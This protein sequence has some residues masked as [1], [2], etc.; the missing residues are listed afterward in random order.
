MTGS[1]VSPTDDDRD[2]REKRLRLIAAVVIAMASILGAIA[3]WHTAKV[4]GAAGGDDGS[5]VNQTL[6]ATRDRSRAEVIAR[7]EQAAF[8]R[9]QSER[10]AATALARLTDE[11][12][13]RGDSQQVE[14]LSNDGQ[15]LDQAAAA[16]AA[17]YPYV[18]ERAAASTPAKLDAAAFD[19]PARRD[20]LVLELQRRRGELDPRPD[21]ARADAARERRHAERLAA[22]VVLFAIAIFT[23]ALAGQLLDRVMPRLAIGGMA[24]VAVAAV[25]TLVLW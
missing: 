17:Q 7:T 18:Q 2:A 19:L 8:V 5:S 6:S 21:L 20:A 13:L 15:S 12:R 11:A 10:A 9:Y 23:L 16:L 22:M 25:G 24:L 1:T 14:L 3:T 4:A